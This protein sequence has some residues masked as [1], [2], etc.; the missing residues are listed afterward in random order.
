MLRVL[1]KQIEEEEGRVLRMNQKK[2]ED[3][4]LEEEIRKT[5]HVGNPQTV[6]KKVGNSKKK[7]KKKR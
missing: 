6:A 7:G 2:E 1:A 3:E 5:T 4:L